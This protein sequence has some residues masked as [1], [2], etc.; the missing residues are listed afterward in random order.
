MKLKAGLWVVVADGARGLVLVNEGTAIEPDLKV[1]RVYEQD[2]PKTSEQGRDKPPRSFQSFGD[3]RS[4]MATPD[5][6]RRAEDRFVEQIIA[7]LGK[8][9]AAN[10]FEGVVI[11][12]PPVALGEMRKAANGA[13]E[14]RIVTW[15]DK[16]LT[17]HSVPDITAA[18]AKVL[19]G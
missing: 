4:A 7:D 19:E 5:L 8:D 3:R 2:N 10:A 11:V 12:A 15:I 18:V 1:L 17:N 14:K 6:H 16:D 13:L 9:A